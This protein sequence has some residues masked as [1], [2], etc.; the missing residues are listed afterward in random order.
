LLLFAKPDGKSSGF[1]FCFE[2]FFNYFILS[3]IL[4]KRQ[5][6]GEVW[7]RRPSLYGYLTA[8]CHKSSDRT[9]LPVGE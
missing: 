5:D 7:R 8:A 4:P 1:F 9:I 2:Q 6:S 3:K